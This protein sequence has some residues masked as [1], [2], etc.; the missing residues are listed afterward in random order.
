VLNICST[1]ESEESMVEK[2]CLC[3]KLH[4]VANTHAGSNVHSIDALG[5]AFPKRQTTW[6][7]VGCSLEVEALSTPWQQ[8]DRCSC[9]VNPPGPWET[10]I[11]ST[12]QLLQHTSGAIL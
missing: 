8:L 3:R 6:P 11:S 10:A 1:D 9:K 7:L 5:W 4:Y 2:D 12:Q